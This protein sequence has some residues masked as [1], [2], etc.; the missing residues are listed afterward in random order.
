MDRMFVLM[1]LA[2][3]LLASLAIGTASGFELKQTGLFHLVTVGNDLLI[4][5][6]ESQRLTCSEH[7][8]L[9]DHPGKHKL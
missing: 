8:C 7:Q 2:A 1:P 3:I 9:F 6:A 5:I 4:M